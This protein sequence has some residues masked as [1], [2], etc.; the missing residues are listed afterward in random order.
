LSDVSEDHSEVI[1]IE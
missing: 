1:F